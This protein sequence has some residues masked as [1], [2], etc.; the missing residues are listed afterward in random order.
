MSV[1]QLSTIVL[2]VLF[3]HFSEMRLALERTLGQM[4]EKRAHRGH[5]RQLACL[6]R[7]HSRRSGKIEAASEIQA[8]QSLRE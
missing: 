7:P 4:R 3:L 2:L 6:S 1:P 5:G 8:A